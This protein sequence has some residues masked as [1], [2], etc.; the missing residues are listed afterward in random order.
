MKKTFGII[1]LGCPRNLVDS[2]C[3]VSEFKKRGYAFQDRAIDV[4][5]VIINTCAFI[6]DAKKE[7]ID[8]ILK[9]IEAKKN[10]ALKKI[11]VAGCLSERYPEELK[12]DLRGVDEFRGVRDFNSTFRRTPAARLTPRHY[13]YIKISEGCKNK[14]TYC[15]I[16]HIKGRY[17]SRDKKSIIKEAKELIQRGVKEIILVGQDTS[18]YGTDLYK[19]KA[20]AE[21]LKELD[22]ISDGAW[23]RLLYCHPANIDKDLIRTIRDSKNIC[24]Y[25]DLPIE[26]ASDRILRR[27]GRK[28][29]KR[30]IISLI[31]HIR[32][33]IPCA[34]IR[35]SLI[36]GFPGEKEKDF[37]ELSTFVK[38]I[39]F[40]RLGLFRYSREENTPAC[41]YKDQVSE[42]KKQSRFDKIMLLQQDIARN[43]NQSFKG[44]TVKVLIEEKKDCYIG[45][46]EYDAPEVDGL[47]YVKGEGL[48][49]GSFYNVRIVDT[50]E[51]DLVGEAVTEERK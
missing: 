2:E 12:K 37:Q 5:T 26:H 46:T 13:A 47:V 19:K 15:I 39:R 16:P 27:M 23:I 38:K 36:V 42:K 31:Q 8:I 1:S 20:L 24:K 11:I 21:L 14:C 28:V 4:D 33:E 18:L 30:D 43:I 3:I 7:S 50:Y 35:T 45:R 22:E 51:Y 32:R 44:R 40:E 10:G 41:K 29:T 25:I 34:A 6:E 49:V 17:R 48:K 9:T